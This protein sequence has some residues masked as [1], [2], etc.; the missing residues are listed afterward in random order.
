[1]PF[2]I[3]YDHLDTKAFLATH[4][5]PKMKIAKVIDHRFSIGF[6]V[7]GNTTGFADFTKCF[8]RGITDLIVAAMVRKF[9]LV[10]L[11][12]KSMLKSI[13]CAD[14]ETFLYYFTKSM[15]IVKT[16]S[17]DQIDQNFS[18]FQTG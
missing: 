16:F 11:F 13:D 4:K 15:R 1:M 14:C 18:T 12:K 3:V 2:T 9:V 7:T 6:A 10:S 8:Q 17:E 5:D